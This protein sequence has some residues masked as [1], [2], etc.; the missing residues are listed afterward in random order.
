MNDEQKKP[1]FLNAHGIYSASAHMLDT[2]EPIPLT[3]A[4]LK[5]GSTENERWF[6]SSQLPSFSLTFTS[7]KLPEWL[8][9]DEQQYEMIFNDYAKALIRSRADLERMTKGEVID[10]DW[11]RRDNGEWVFLEAGKLSMSVDSEDTSDE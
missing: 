6:N 3:I 1:K 4:P 5:V 11:Y 8:N 9:P 10:V 7:D 2:G